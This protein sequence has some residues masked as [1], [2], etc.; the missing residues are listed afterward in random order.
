MTLSRPPRATHAVGLLLA[1]GFLALGPLPATRAADDAVVAA[2]QRRWARDLSAAFREAARRVEPSVVH[3]D[4]LVDAGRRRPAGSIDEMFEQLFGIERPDQ[5]RGERP[6]RAGLGSGIVVREEGVIVTNHHVVSG[7][8]RLRVHLDDG[9]ELE[10]VVLGVDAEADLAVIHVDADDLVPA[11]LGD[12]DGVDVGEWVLAVGSPFGLSH[13][14]TAGIVS[15]T[16]R[17][18]FGL[19]TFEDYIQ[20]D[21]AINP[22]N[23]GGPLTNLD[24]EVIGV[25]TAINTRTGGSMGIGFAIPSRMVRKVVDDILREGHVARG[26][27]GV[28]LA[29]LTADLSARLGYAGDDG[30]VVATVIPDTPAQRAGLAVGDIIRSVNGTPVTEIRELRNLIADLRPRDV[31]RLRIV[32]ELRDETYSIRLGERPTR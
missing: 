6:R 13:T 18:G 3:I 28:S 9:R 16:G 4:S 27:L 1:L 17:A 31:A 26:W 20:T 22:G 24:G 8:D 23:S 5:G 25:N 11:R 19:A 14:V 7:A 15:A 30:V 12:S 29:P 10:A 21:A 2:E 32:R